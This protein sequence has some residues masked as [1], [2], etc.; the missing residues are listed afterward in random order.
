MVER[1][2]D[3]VWKCG[4]TPHEWRKAIIVPICNKGS[5][6]ECGNYRGISLLSVVGKIYA[7]VVCDRLRLLTDVLLTD[8][9]GGFRVR[10]VCVDKIFAVRQVIEKDKMVYAAFVD[11]E[12]AYGSV[13]RSKLRVALKDYGVRGRLLAAV[14][15]F[16][17]EGWARV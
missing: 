10:R 5:R 17:E 4:K 9:Q 12:K 2:F 8:E 15:S 13:S 6:D 3:I 1:R 16:Y 7:R 11:L 14:Q